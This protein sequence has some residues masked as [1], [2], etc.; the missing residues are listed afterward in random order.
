MS[1]QNIKTTG[2]SSSTVPKATGRKDVSAAAQY[3]KSKIIKKEKEFV[4]QNQLGKAQD[5]KSSEMRK[6]VIYRLNQAKK[7]SF[8]REWHW[9][10]AFFIWLL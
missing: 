4:K 9:G 1:N 7:E 3:I 2:K 10:L 6:E 8:I 5:L